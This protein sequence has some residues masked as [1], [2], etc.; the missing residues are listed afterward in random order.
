[1]S[2]D[3][4]T[5]SD[6]QTDPASEGERPTPQQEDDDSA[7]AGTDHSRDTEIGESDPNADSAE[8]LAGGMGVSS[9]R[10]GPARGESEPVS[11]GIH[12]THHP[13]PPADAVPEQSSDPAA[14]PE[15]QPDQP[16]LKEHPA[17]DPAFR[18]P[19]AYEG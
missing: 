12:E 8:G 16:V 5:T 15:V 18:G 1:M 3:P 13:V 10:V 2:Q 17:E 6:P 14:G 4:D 9:E 11:Y 19:A 7:G